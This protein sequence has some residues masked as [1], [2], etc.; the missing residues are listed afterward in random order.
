DEL[1]KLVNS[2]DLN[3][4]VIDIKDDDGRLTYEVDSDSPYAKYSDGHIDDL[5]K[6]LKLLEKEE[7]YPIARVV[8]FKDTQFTDEQPELSFIDN[9]KVWKNNRGEAFVNHFETEVWEHNLEIAKT[10]TE[11]A[12]EDIH[13]AHV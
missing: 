8:V 6:L 1:L 7:I 5:P 12:S 2:T 11:L 13:L 4:M 3:S 9:G 10:G